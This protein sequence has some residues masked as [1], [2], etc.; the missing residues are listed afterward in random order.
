[1]TLLSSITRTFMYSSRVYSTNTRMPNFIKALKSTNAKNL[2]TSN[3]EK[4]NILECYDNLADYWE[5]KHIVKNYVNYINKTENKE[6]EYTDEDEW[7]RQKA[8]EHAFKN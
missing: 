2:D 4:K 5:H 8:A 7:L 3:N 1:M 6:Y